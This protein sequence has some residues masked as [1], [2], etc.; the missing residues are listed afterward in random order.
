MALAYLG[1][2]LRTNLQG[3]VFG[4]VAHIHVQ[5]RKLDPKALKCYFI[6]YSSTQEGNRLYNQKSRK[7]FM[8]IDVTL[9][10]QECSSRAYMKSKQLNKMHLK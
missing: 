4:C 9:N 3:R 7:F 1:G 8:S 5:S 6:G 10:E 2:R